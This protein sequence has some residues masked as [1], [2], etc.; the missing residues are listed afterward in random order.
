MG[1]C[2]SFSLAVPAARLFTTEMSA[3]ISMCMRPSQPIAVQ[4]A[5]RDEITLWLFLEEWDDPLPWR[6]KRHVQIELATDTSRTGWVGVI[7]TPVKQEISD[8]WSKD[9]MMF[10]ITTWEAF[11]VDKVLRAFKDLVKD[12]R[13]DVMI[14]NLAVMHAWNNQG[15]K[16]RDLNNAIKALFF[17]TMDLNI[18]LHMLYIPSQE[19][20]ADAPSRRLSS[21]DYT[22]ASEIWNNVQLT[23]GGG[24]GHSCDL[25]ALDS[26]AMSDKLGHPLP[27]FA[28]HPSPGS[29]GVNLLAQDLTQFSAIM[30][31]PYVF[32]PNV[33][34]GPVLLFLQS[35]RQS[36]IVV[37][38]DTYPRE[39]WWP[40]L[41]RFA[42]KGGS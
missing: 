35:Y 22:L 13:V 30:Q 2:I 32:P 29:I 4:V 27:H 36:G 19:N 18:L 42:R 33:L 28:P 38:L 9:E 25:M 40:L 26:N 12:C 23:F 5:L 14:D 20:P 16:G 39:Y 37:I 8:Y 11:A 31:R 7:S 10:D 41:Q 6:E 15:G 3:A 34:V 17:T 21:L 24:Q 1:K